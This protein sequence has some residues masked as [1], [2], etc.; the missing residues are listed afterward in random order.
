M[1]TIILLLGIGVVL[2]FFEIVVPGAILG[3]LG[4]LAMLG[5]VIVAFIEFGPTGGVATTLIAV[6]I[7]AIVLYIELRILPNTRLGKRMFLHSAV[8]ASTQP[9]VADF[10]IV[11][12]TGEAATIL[13]P[14]GFVVVEGRRLE[15]FSQSGYIEPGTTVRVDAVD[16]FRVIVSKP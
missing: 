7:L 8:N 11:G 1:N 9:P 13:A 6:A 2:F 15:A 12:K 10:S 4:G 14:S 3:T 5:G 16:N